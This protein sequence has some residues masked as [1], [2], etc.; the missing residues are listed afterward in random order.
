MYLLNNSLILQRQYSAGRGAIVGHGRRPG[1]A[2]PV[3]PSLGGKSY[4]NLGH[5]KYDI[6]FF[7]KSESSLAFALPSLSQ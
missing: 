2:E 1:S 5:Q 7:L 4:K 3:S 6:Y